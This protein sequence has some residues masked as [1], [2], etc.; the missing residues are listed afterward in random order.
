MNAELL[1]ALCFNNQ[2]DQGDEK[3]GLYTVEG[4]I[5]GDRLE[6]LIL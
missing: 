3:E 4:G 1:Y 5:R 2:T 6:R